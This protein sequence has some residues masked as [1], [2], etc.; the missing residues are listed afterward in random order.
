MKDR[1]IKLKN[2][3]SEL[4]VDILGAQI[5]SYKVDGVEVMY[6]GALNPENSKWKFS[7]KNLFP[8]P[9]PVGT[10]NENGELNTAEYHVRDGVVEKHVEYTHNGGIYHMGQHGPIQHKKFTINGKTKDSCVLSVRSDDYTYNEYPYDFIY[11]MVLGLEK[12]GSL[13]YKTIAQNNDTKPMLAGMGWHPA[14]ALHKNPSKYTIIFKNLNAKPDAKITRTVSQNGTATKVSE[15]LKA[16][17]EYTI[18]EN[19]VMNGKSEQITGIESADIVLLYENEHGEKIPYITMHTEEPVLILWSRPKDNVSQED[20]LCIEPWNTTPRQ[21]NKLITQDKTRELK[22]TGAVIIEPNEQSELNASVYIN[23]E[24]LKVL[25][26][27]N[28]SSIQC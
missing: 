23:P 9:G 22:K 28:N 5:V 3:N 14:F 15:P 27:E 21:I 17:T 26:L 4:V 20:F 1:Y 8:N 19:I 10:S 24:F 13:S 7:S 6:Q 2:G 11:Y 12:D 16:D 18:D 25:E